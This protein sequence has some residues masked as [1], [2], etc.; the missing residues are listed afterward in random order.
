M[1]GPLADVPHLVTALGLASLALLGV[2]VQVPTAAPPDA[3]GVAD[4]V[5]AAAASEYATQATHPLQAEA[6]K[7]GARSI[8]LRNDAGTAHARFAFGPVTPAGGNESLRRVA[9]G[10][11]P[12]QAF[13]SSRSFRQALRT[14]RNRSASWHSADEI[15]VRRLTW[16]GVDATLVLA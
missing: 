6:V 12:R 8:A 3:A 11:P 4:T 16:R 1:L 9:R 13:D 10:T 5:D 7:L 2:A 14:A 15:V